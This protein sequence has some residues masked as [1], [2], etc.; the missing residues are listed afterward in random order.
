[1]EYLAR[2]LKHLAELGVRDHNL[3]RVMDAVQLLRKS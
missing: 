2:T 1:V 3:L